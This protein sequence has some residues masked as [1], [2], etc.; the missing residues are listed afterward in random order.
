MLIR[1]HVR[2]AWGR[3]VLSFPLCLAT[4]FKCYQAP[5]SLVRCPRHRLAPQRD[6]RTSYRS[7]RA[8]LHVGMRMS[9][10]FRLTVVGGRSESVVSETQCLF[11]FN[12]QV[13][14]RGASRRPELPRASL[15]PRSVHRATPAPSAPS[16][17]SVN[18]CTSV[19]VRPH[20]H[21]TA[22]P[23]ITTTI[24]IASHQCIQ[25]RSWHMGSHMCPAH[26]LLL[27][28]PVDLDA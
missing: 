2:G 17:S 24:T 12:I 15:A 20:P 9:Y 11:Y 5:A 10:G 28:L 6:L 21:H 19:L 13:S 27:V 7:R 25:A 8:P 22:R 26:P 23:S 3:F 16:Q 1:V 14:N 4:E 18:A